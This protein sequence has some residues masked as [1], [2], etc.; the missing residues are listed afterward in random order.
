LPDSAALP[1]AQDPD[2]HRTTA[3]TTTIEITGA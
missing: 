1:A 2:H 3:T